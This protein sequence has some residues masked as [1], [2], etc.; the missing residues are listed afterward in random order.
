MFKRARNVDDPSA[1]STP[2]PYKR[3][4]LYANVS[5][6][7][8]PQSSPASLFTPYNSSCAYSI[9]SDSPSNPFGLKRTLAALTLPREIGFSKHLALRFQLVYEDPKGKRTVR[10]SP[11]DLD[12]VH[13]IAQVPTNYTFRHLHKLI[14]FLFATDARWSKPPGSTRPTRHRRS[15]RLKAPFASAAAKGDAE[16]APLNRQAG[17]DKGKGKLGE[18]SVSCPRVS[19][20]IPP[21]WP[22]HF[23]EVREDISLYRGGYKPGVIKPHAGKTCVRLSS[24]RDR[25]LFP[26]LYEQEHSSLY[27]ATMLGS[28]STSSTLDVLE[29]GFEDDDDDDA[30]WRWEGEDDY[31]VRHVWPNGPELEKGIVYRHLPGVSVHITINT[32][33]VPP[34]KGIGNQPFVFRWRGS[35]RGAIRIA[36][37]IPTD[38]RHA[39]AP[40]PDATP[41]EIFEDEK[42][43]DV[44][45]LK[46][47]N[48]RDAFSRFLTLEADRERALRRSTSSPFSPSTARPSMSANPFYSSPFRRAAHTASL[49]PSSPVSSPAT[50][51]HLSSA[52]SR[53]AYT[54][55]S[56]LSQSSRRSSSVSLVGLALFELPLETPA[57]AHPALARRV[58]RASRRLERLTRCGL[59]D[60]SDGEES[61]EVLGDELFADE[62]DEGAD[63]ESERERARE[64][65]EALRGK[66][67]VGSV[68]EEEWDPFGEDEL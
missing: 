54:A 15:E 21:E 64:V 42:D 40:E 28:S 1:S 58:A 59:A 48:D 61:D 13:R 17:R 19:D 43:S 29:T 18:P 31:T 33:R 2:S 68:P 26:D 62:V 46:R 66:Q 12:G 11:L 37:L 27:H 49:P 24:V 36:H 14:L 25:K 35:T 6:P 5:S 32:A 52:S 9:P 23:F 7:T 20:H 57:P 16:N 30:G 55:S 51:P 44:Q 56:P 45:R 53:S 10:D 3:V 8:R 38:N 67:W 4:R 65:C 60:M 47:W 22:G 63:E 39:D 41:E 34:R 50:L